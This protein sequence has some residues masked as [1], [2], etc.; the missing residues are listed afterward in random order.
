MHSVAQRPGI[1]QHRR[2]R[3]DRAKKRLFLA[4][5]PEPLRKL[6]AR[7][8]ILGPLAAAGKNDRVVMGVGDIGE[9]RVGFHLNAVRALDKRRFMDGCYRNLYA[10]ATQNVNDGERFDVFKPL[11]QRYECICHIAP[12]FRIKIP[13]MRFF[14]SLHFILRP[15]IS[16]SLSFSQAFSASGRLG[17]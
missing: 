7:F 5:A 13:Q 11:S 15:R 4:L 8:K 1:D 2:R 14:A 17:I 9:E 10:A 12:P 6:S 16:L 3:A